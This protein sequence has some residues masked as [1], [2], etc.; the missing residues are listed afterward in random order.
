MGERAWLLKNKIRGLLGA[1]AVPRTCCKDSKNHGPLLDH[2]NGQTHRQCLKCNAKH[3]EL[4][5]DPNRPVRK[6][7]L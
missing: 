3:Y 1:K 2:G 6:L 7:A 4:S 5:V